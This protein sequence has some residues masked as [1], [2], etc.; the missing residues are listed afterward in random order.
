MYDEVD[1]KELDENNL[2]TL[3]DGKSRCHLLFGHL[4]SWKSFNP[5]VVEDCKIWSEK[6]NNRP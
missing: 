4:L 1:D 2:I 5:N 6:I 3:C